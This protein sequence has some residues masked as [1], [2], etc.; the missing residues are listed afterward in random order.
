MK[1]DEWREW[2]N[3]KRV[4]KE[5]AKKRQVGCEERQVAS[6]TRERQSGVGDGGWDEKDRGGDDTQPTKHCAL[7]TSTQLHR[8]W[9]TPTRP[10]KDTHSA[11]AARMRPTTAEATSDTREAV[12][13]ATAHFTASQSRCRCL[14]CS[15]DTSSEQRHHLELW[16]SGVRGAGFLWFSVCRPAARAGVTGRA[17]SRATC[18]APAACVSGNKRAGPTKHAHGHKRHGPAAAWFGQ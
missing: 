16:R 6:S 7:S 2:K 4:S 18:T 14:A 3:E 12:H 9:L 15:S 10:H 5:D 8:S 13:E 11:R 1:R 17:T